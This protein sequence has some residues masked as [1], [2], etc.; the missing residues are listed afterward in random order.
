MFYQSNLWPIVHSLLERFLIRWIELLMLVQ[1]GIV[2]IGFYCWCWWL[3]LASDQD[4][5]LHYPVIPVTVS[6][7]R[8]QVLGLWHQSLPDKI[9]PDYP[10]T[11]THLH[12]PPQVHWDAH[13]SEA[14]TWSLRGIELYTFITNVHRS[15]YDPR[16]RLINQEEVMSY[17]MERAAVNG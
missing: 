16:L 14:F 10:L 11:R 12:Q 3:K 17:D 2:K 13:S 15:R 1:T 7:D 6:L 4:K 8:S 9:T 5:A